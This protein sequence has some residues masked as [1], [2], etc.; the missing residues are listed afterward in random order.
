MPI[1]IINK[2]FDSLEKNNRSLS[3]RK[4][5][6]LGFAFKG[7]PET[8]DM[9]DSP[10]LDLVKELKLKGVEI[11]GH[12]PLVDKKEIE[13]LGVS[14][15]D[16]QF[17]FEIADAIIIMTNHESYEDLNLSDLISKDKELI[18]IDGWS[19]FENKNL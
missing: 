13:E 1:H 9:R 19:T 4:I 6:V 17:G 5:F 15:V 8:S 18:I 7:K 16:L 10:T 12:D 14:F 2:L 3:D 11:Y